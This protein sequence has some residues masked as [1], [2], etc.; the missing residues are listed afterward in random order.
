M[1]INYA[2][3][4]Q[5]FEA[6]VRQTGVTRERERERGGGGGGGRGAKQIKSHV[7]LNAERGKRQLHVKLRPT[8]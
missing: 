6:D 3:S 4:L 5:L 7:V 1:H 2:A 8:Q